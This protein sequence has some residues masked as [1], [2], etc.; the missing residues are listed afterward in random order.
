[1]DAWLNLLQQSG[2]AHWVQA[3][4]YPAVI[5]LH[6]IGL[7]ILV[8][9]LTLI[10]LRVLGFVRELPLTALR[11]LMGVVWI[12]FAINAVSGVMLFSIDARK[13]FHSGLFRSKMAAIAV[14]LILGILIRSRAL[15]GPTA[16]M[17]AEAAPDAKLFAVLSLIVWT[18]AIVSGRLLAYSTFGDVE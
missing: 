11:R 2:F 13:D 1:M 7:A 4:A 14:G 3:S 6:S 15:V 12:G 8:G 16:Q 5:T 10:D 18:G 9:V 17:Q